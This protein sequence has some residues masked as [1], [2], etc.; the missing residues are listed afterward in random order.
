MNSVLRHAARV[1]RKFVMTRNWWLAASAVL[2]G[3]MLADMLGCGRTSDFSYP[4]PDVAA[5]LEFR[6]ATSTGAAAAA[7]VST[8]TG[9]AT[10]KGQFRLAGSPP[11]FAP[12]GTGG[13]DSQVCG[14]QV[15]DNSLIV[16]SGNQ[17]IANVVVYARKVSRVHESGQQ[18]P[19]EPA[20]FDQ[21]G[22]LFLA[23]VVPVQVG[24]TVL[25]KNSDPVAHNTAIQPPL[26]AGANP[27]LPANSD[28]NYKFS[29]PQNLPVPV[30]CSIHPWMKAFMLPRNDPYMAVSGADGSFEIGNLPAGEEIEFQVW[31][32]RAPNVAAGT[33]D[34]RIANGRFKIKLDADQTRD[35]GA[36]EVP[37]TAFGG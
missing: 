16:D 4:R 31:H 24:Q 8:A 17:G 15:P 30:T 32:E 18:P 1:L 13:K 33:A 6:E 26:D 29:R 7:P 34:V 37:G 21:K 36:I 12:I 19:Q 28:T 20:L 22:C 14:N 35:L 27:L 3:V 25:I 23:R 5:A 10:L 11:S 9:W 2:A